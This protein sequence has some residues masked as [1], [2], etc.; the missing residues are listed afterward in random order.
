M[1]NFLLISGTGEAAATAWR[2][3]LAQAQR[4]KG[5]APAR[6]WETA[7]LWVASWSGKSPASRRRSPIGREHREIGF[8]SNLAVDRRRAVDHGLHCLTLPL[9][10]TTE[11]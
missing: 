6:V 3:G 1:G 2:H 5:S 11:K 8:E 7:G 4:L 10:C 9:G